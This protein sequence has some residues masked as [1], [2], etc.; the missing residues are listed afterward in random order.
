MGSMHYDLI[1]DP[2]QGTLS[3]RKVQTEV[4]KDLLQTFPVDNNVVGLTPAHCST[5][6]RSMSVLIFKCFLWSVVRALRLC[7][8]HP[9][10]KQRDVVPSFERVKFY[11]TSA[12]PGVDSNHAE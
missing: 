9:N 11:E 4:A 7:V 8:S 2:R 10:N 1:V 3:R 12:L 6:C 5:Q